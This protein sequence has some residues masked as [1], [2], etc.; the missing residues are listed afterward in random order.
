[1]P[2]VHSP[3]YGIQ[4]SAVRQAINSPVQATA[5]DFTLLAMVLIYEHMLNWNVPATVLGQV[6][7]SIIVEVDAELSTGLAARIKE[8]M[9]EDV[10]HEVH[11]R[12]GYKF[13]LPLGAEVIVSKEW[14]GKPKLVLA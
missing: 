13:P 2:D 4:H 12:F 5:S 10:P 9:E 3:E 6:H 1:M 8:I 11:K 14:G 7:D